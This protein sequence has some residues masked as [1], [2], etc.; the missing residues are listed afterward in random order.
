M[1]T[2]AHT[3]APRDSIWGQVQDAEEIAPGWWN[4]STAGHGG[5][6]LSAAR[7][8][9][10]SPDILARTFRE[11]GEHGIFEEDCD[12]CVP[13]L[14]WPEEFSAYLTRQGHTSEKIAFYLE[15]AQASFNRYL[16]QTEQS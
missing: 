11:Q 6:I 4:V 16:H 15:C 7:V 8:A 10:I 2:Y 13:V 3:P 14:T 12:W 9:D 1:K 5:M